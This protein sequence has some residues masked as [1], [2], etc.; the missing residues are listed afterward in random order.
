MNHPTAIRRNARINPRQGLSLK[1]FG[2]LC[3]LGMPFVAVSQEAPPP[4]LP[5]EAGAILGDRPAVS[6]MVKEIEVR[7]RTGVTVDRA[8][9]LSR[10]T[11]KQGE[12]W[13]Q[14]KE[15]EDLKAFYKSG[16]LTNVT[17]DTVTQIQSHM[18]AH[19]YGDLL[20]KAKLKGGKS[21]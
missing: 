17:I 1:L 3:A 18:L 20:K 5:S 7:F 9:I 2:L 12:A 6:R 19:Q 11:L 10:M 4:E 8:R 15:E 13:T 16:D 14:D 21:R